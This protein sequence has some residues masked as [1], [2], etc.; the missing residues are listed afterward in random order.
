MKLG[1]RPANPAGCI[2]REVQTAQG[3]PAK[4]QFGSKRIMGKNE[5]SMGDASHC[6]HLSPKNSSFLSNTLSKRKYVMI[7]WTTSIYH[8]YDHKH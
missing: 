1:I 2:H 4:Y 5:E 7:A 3:P 6:E 8:L